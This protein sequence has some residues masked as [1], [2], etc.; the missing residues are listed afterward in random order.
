MS[1]KTIK[2]QIKV[3]LD[4]LVTD[5]VLAGA[6]ITDL[7][8][9]PLA[10]DIPNFP[11]AFLMPPAIESELNDNRSNL[12]SYV[13]DIMILLNAENITSAT[14]VEE[15]VQSVL[16]KFDNDPTLN[17]TAMAGMLPVSTAPQPFQH[18][19]RDLIMVVVQIS[20]KDIINLTFS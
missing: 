6:T 7:K 15:M 8:K 19:T 16:D 11:H 17:G 13:F 18:G 1:L 5:E 9:D 10:A 20:A 14:D 3:K 12:R 4:E 2:E